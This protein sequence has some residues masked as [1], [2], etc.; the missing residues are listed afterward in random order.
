MKHQNI[1]HEKIEEEFL[2]LDLNSDSFM[3]RKRLSI[4]ELRF[5]KPL[6]KMK[7]YEAFF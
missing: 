2:N 7:S 6:Y 4:W 5:I 3:P 1:I